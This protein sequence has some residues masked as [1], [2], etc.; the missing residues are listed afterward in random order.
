MVHLVYEVSMKYVGGEILHVE[1]ILLTISSHTYRVTNRSNR[2]RHGGH[3]HHIIGWFSSQ[4]VC[5]VSGCDCECE[6]DAAI[7]LSRPAIC[8][9]ADD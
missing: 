8:V 5:P 7:E 4:K 1:S 9:K 6:F 2:C 3:A